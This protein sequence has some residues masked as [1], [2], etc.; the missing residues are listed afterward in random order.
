VVLG[1]ADGAA[2]VPTS[3]CD[4]SA[5]KVD[6]VRC[7]SA[8][9]PDPRAEGELEQRRVAVPALEVEQQVAGLEPFEDDVCFALPSGSM[10]LGLDGALSTITSSAT[11]AL[12]SAEQVR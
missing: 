11:A 10:P 4:P 6:V 3:D 2:V 12:N 1:G 9:L 8:D 7:Q 5:A